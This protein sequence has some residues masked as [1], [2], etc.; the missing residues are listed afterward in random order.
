QSLPVLLLSPQQIWKPRDIGGN[1]ARLWRT[2]CAGK[3]I[4]N[5]L[6]EQG[7]PPYSKAASKP[8][9]MNMTNAQATS[10]AGSMGGG[11]AV[12]KKKVRRGDSGPEE[13]PNQSQRASHWLGC[14]G[15]ASRYERCLA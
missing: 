14:T 15:T 10:M 6:A 2:Q 13:S 1:P 9:T 11:A 3:W 4:T 5:F 8:Q 7:R 12:S